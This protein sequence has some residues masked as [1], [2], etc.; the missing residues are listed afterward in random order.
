M[1]EEWVHGYRDEMVYHHG[2]I[3]I[4][5][6]LYDLYYTI[7][8]TW[9]YKPCNPYIEWVGWI[10]PCAKSTSLFSEYVLRIKKRSCG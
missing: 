6:I 5:I 10:I 1:A 2:Y 8:T 9:L 3:P 7:Y 4:C